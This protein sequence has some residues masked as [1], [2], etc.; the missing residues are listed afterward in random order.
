MGVIDSWIA[1]KLSCF[2][3]R[4]V[5]NE[6]QA[7]PALTYFKNDLLEQYHTIAYKRG[8]CQV[9]SIILDV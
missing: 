6:L 3:W 7:G 8:I 1:V 5:F 4:F 2:T 9:D